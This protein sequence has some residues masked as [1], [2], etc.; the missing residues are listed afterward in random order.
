M[1]CIVVTP[2]KT[3]VDED[4][5]FIVAPLY[6]GEYGID[7]DH[8]PVVGRLGVGEMRSVLVYRRGNP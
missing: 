3:L 5:K 4:A 1:K 8:A 2:E 6:D 7:S